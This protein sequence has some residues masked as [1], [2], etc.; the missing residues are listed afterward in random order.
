MIKEQFRMQ[1]LAGIITESQYKEKINDMQSLEDL[2]VGDHYRIESI[3]SEGDDITTDY[4]YISPI[5]GY[6]VKFQLIKS[7]MNDNT[8]EQYKKLNLTH[9]FT[10]GSE[11]KFTK[12]YL[13]NKI[14]K[15]QLYKI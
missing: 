4:E 13:Q 5:G 10:P 6:D 14:N 3:N 9:F 2:K 8:K 11:T 7:Y 15:G 1:V 12:K